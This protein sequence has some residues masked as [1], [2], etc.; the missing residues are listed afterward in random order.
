MCTLSRSHTDTVAIMKC[1]IY[2]SL[3]LLFGTEIM[4]S[5]DYSIDQ[6]SYRSTITATTVSM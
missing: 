4:P 1:I 3:H 2:M 5:I 6:Y